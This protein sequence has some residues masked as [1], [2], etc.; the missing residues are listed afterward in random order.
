MPNNKK[1]KSPKDLAKKIYI[2]IAK[3]GYTLDEYFIC[4]REVNRMVKQNTKVESLS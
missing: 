2:E 1:R 4:R 3:Q